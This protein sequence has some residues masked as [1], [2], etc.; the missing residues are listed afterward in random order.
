MSLL[1]GQATDASTLQKFAI[2]EY[3]YSFEMSFRDVGRSSL[4]PIISSP[5]RTNKRRNCPPREQPSPSSSLHQIAEALKDHE[6]GRHVLKEQCL[7]SHSTTV[8]RYNSPS[9]VS[10]FSKLNDEIV[11]FQ[12]MVNELHKVVDSDVMTPEDQWR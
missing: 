1:L 2:F 10:A 3:L 7:I 4:A 9:C 8:P 6:R 12:K 5:R 11:Q